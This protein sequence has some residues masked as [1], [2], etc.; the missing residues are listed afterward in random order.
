MSAEGRK[1]P[2]SSR[3]PEATAFRRWRIHNTVHWD[4]VNQVLGREGKRFKKP[5]ST[6]QLKVSSRQR[7]VHYGTP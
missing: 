4:K 5:G 2:A 3:N 6:G 1:N 7:E